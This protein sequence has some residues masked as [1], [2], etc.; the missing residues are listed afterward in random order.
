LAD[1]FAVVVMAW[2]SAQAADA[3]LACR[4]AILAEALVEMPAGVVAQEASEALLIEQDVPLLFPALSL[5]Q[6]RAVNNSQ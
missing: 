2:A 6:E 1:I 3:L 5:Y 4:D